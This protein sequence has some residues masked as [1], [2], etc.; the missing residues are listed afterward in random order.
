MEIA[1]MMVDDYD[2]RER[3]ERRTEPANMKLGYH[4]Q[5]MSFLLDAEDG[6]WLLSPFFLSVF[7]SSSFSER[8]EHTSS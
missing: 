6:C 8:H 5:G 2:E 1:M 4:E 7:F 3:E